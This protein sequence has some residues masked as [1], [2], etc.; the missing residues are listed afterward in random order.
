MD[1]LPF[2]DGERTAAEAAVA[3]KTPPEE[4]GIDEGERLSIAAPEG[5]ATDAAKGKDGIT[6]PEERF[7][8]REKMSA[9]REAVPPLR[10][11]V[12]PA[13]GVGFTVG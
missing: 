2:D 6:A 8:S 13:G 9:D 7:G 3:E 12:A 4:I 1:E 10:C 11:N 5:G